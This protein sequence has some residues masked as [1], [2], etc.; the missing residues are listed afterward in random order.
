MRCI[1]FNWFSPLQWHFFSDNSRC[2]ASSACPGW[3]QIERC[4][5]VDGQHNLVTGSAQEVAV[6][7]KE[8]NLLT[9][10][11]GRGGGDGGRASYT[12]AILCKDQICGAFNF[13]SFLL[14]FSPRTVF[15]H[16]V[17]QPRCSYILKVFPLQAQSVS[18]CILARG[19]LF[20]YV[21]TRLPAE[22]AYR[23][24][25]NKVELGAR[26]DWGY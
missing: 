23:M 8:A 10:K 3:Q 21:S 5:Y 18:W 20:F 7:Q 26:A 1:F 24:F 12:T 14:F 6:V 15:G 13:F 2:V 4:L 16:G 22:L 17:W 11:F 25:I 19:W 9:W